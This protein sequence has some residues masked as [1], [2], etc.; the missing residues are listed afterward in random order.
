MPLNRSARPAQNVIVSYAPGEVRLRDRKLATSTL[1]SADRVR[2]W[3]VACVGDLGPHDVDLWL[4]GR[5]EIVI[6]STG[7]QQRFPPAE[8]LARALS[9]GVGVEVMAQGAACRTYNVLVEDGRAV[10]LALIL[11]GPSAAEGEQR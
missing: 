5:P 4:D 7:E 3:P 11:D 6:L 10:L 9:A 1:L 2:D 8:L